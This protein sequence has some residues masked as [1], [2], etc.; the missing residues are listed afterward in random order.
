MSELGF[1][2]SNPP[3]FEADPSSFQFQGDHLI[4]TRAGCGLEEEKFW[5][6]KINF[7]SG[8]TGELLWFWWE[9]EDQEGT[10]YY[11]P[12]DKKH[13]FRTYIRLIIRK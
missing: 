8:S 1:G 10:G 11:I 7:R 3:V 4:T 9:K 12:G 5:P 13:P 6:K 2:K